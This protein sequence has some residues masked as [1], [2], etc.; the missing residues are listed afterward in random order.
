MRRV[1]HNDRLEFPNVLSMKDYVTDHVIAKDK[2]QKEVAKKKEH[3]EKKM[4]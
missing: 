4:A 3:Q 2:K 1:K